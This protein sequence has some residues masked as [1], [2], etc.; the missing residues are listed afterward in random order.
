MTLR[1]LS[2]LAVVGA[3]RGMTARLEAVAGMTVEADFLPTVGLL[4]R[5]RGGE[6]AD[7]AILT[8]D[9]IGQLCADGVLDPASRKDLVR[10]HVGF[11]VKAGA[12]HPDLG[13]LD[14]LRETLRAAPSVAYSRTG[15]SGIAF[16]GLIE[17][18]GIAEEVNAKARIIQAGFTAE[19]AASGE[20]AI[21][22][23]QVSE[24]LAVPGIEV[25]GRLPPEVE[26]VAVFSAAIFRG[27]AQP[28]AAER[29]L[30][31]LASRDAAPTLEAAGLEPILPP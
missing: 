20:V 10:S 18:L 9:G 6:R 11:A 2:T 24:L 13:S 22:V 15:A 31:F 29:L 28:V 26:V 4:Q 17:R 3:M 14:A 23:Q 12:P 27:A 1:I 7:L 25:A 8:A 16:A 21:A 30:R 19:L 5:I